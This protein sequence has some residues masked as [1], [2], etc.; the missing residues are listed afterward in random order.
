MSDMVTKIEQNLSALSGLL[1]EDNVEDIKKRIADLIVERVA[2]DIR[3]YDYYLFYPP[4]YASCIEDSFESINK[5]ITKMYKDTMLE[6]AKDAVNRF[7]DISL[8][9]SN[10]TNGLM[11]RECHKCEHRNGNKCKFYEDRKYYWIAHDTICAEEGFINYKEKK[12]ESKNGKTYE[13]LKY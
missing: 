12:E 13:Y 4:D 11:L 9:I 6:C 2:S 7:K 5:K 1:G 3:S 10:D 8:S